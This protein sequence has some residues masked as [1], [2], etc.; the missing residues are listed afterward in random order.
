MS[1][2]EALQL[3]IA[4]LGVVASLETRYRFIERVVMV[5]EDWYIVRTLRYELA[6]SNAGGP[7]RD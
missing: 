3:L 5:I 6:L 4:T 1:A 2:N 7:S